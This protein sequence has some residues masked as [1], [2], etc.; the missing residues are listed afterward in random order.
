[1]FAIL[2]SPISYLGLP[3]VFLS[4][5]PISNPISPFTLPPRISK[6]YFVL[7][8]HTILFLTSLAFIFS[9]LPFV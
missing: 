5:A 3:L 9:Y 7:F 2:C 6:S 4:K 1:M 8:Q